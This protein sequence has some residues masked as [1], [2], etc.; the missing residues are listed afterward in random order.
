MRVS[1]RAGEIIIRCSEDEFR[2]INRHIGN[3]QVAPTLSDVRKNILK[4][5]KDSF[6]LA[7][8]ELFK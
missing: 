4:Q 3:A 5:V 2:E 8:M 6:R 1:R 7:K